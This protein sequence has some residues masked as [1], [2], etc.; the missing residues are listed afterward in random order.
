MWGIDQHISKTGLRA[1]MLSIYFRSRQKPSVTTSLG[2]MFS[3]D[4]GSTC[5]R[6]GKAE[7]DLRKSTGMA[8]SVFSRRSYRW[9]A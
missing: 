4:P 1:K 7:A 8:G 5:A 6:M 2:G 3:P 9:S